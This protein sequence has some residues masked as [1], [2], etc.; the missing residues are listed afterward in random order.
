MVAQFLDRVPQFGFEVLKPAREFEDRAAAS[1]G[2]APLADRSSSFSPSS[3]SSRCSA[4]ETAGGRLRPLAYLRGKLF[5]ASLGEPVKL[6]PAIIL[7]HAPFR[8]D[9]AFLFEFEEHR[10]QR[11]VIDRQQIVAG[12]LDAAR[13]AVPVPRAHGVERLK[14]H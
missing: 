1:V 12:L 13:D 8:R 14:D 7:R 4:L 11:A 9:G 5:L 10:L 6:S 2:V 3:V